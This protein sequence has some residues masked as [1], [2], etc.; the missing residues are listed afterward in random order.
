[1]QTPS[2]FTTNKS[3]TNPNAEIKNIKFRFGLWFLNLFEI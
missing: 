2:Q 3:Q 1:M